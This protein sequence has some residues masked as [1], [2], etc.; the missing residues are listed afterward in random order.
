MVDH[1]RRLEAVGPQCDPVPARQGIG[2]DR[3]TWV[4]DRRSAYDAYWAANSSREQQAAYHEIL[5]FGGRD[6]YCL[7]PKLAVL[8]VR[9]LRRMSYWIERRY[10]Q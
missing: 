4:T 8:V 5:L 1:Q 3:V 10:C 9:V 2:D 6:G 7:E